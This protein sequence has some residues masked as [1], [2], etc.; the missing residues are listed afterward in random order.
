MNRLPGTPFFPWAASDLAVGDDPEARTHDHV[1]AREERGL[2]CLLDDSR[3]AEH[4]PGEVLVVV[5]IDVLRIHRGGRDV[6][7]RHAGDRADLPPL[8]LELVKQGGHEPAVVGDVHAV[9]VRLDAADHLGGALRRVGVGVQDAA[10]GQHARPVGRAGRLA[11]EVAGGLRAER[12]ERP[13]VW[14]GDPGVVAAA[15]AVWRDDDRLRID[16]GPVL[17]VRRAGDDEAVLRR[18]AGV[19]ILEDQ[20]RAFSLGVDLAGLDD[21]RGLRGR[22]VQA[23]EPDDEQVLDSPGNRL[24][25]HPVQVALVGVDGAGVDRVLGQEAVESP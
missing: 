23:V 18:A 12:A 5:A 9:V 3:Q 13:G 11:L 6:V 16:V 24:F 25:L 10:D 21:R 4:L 17:V 7:E 22:P 2:P 15:Q 1:E 8:L 20:A 19:V 14:A